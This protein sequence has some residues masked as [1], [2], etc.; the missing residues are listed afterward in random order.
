MF[1]YVFYLVVSCQWAVRRIKNQRTIASKKKKKSHHRRFSVMLAVLCSRSTKPR[2]L[3][4][5][6]SSFAHGSAVHHHHNHYYTDPH[7]RFVPGPGSGGPVQFADLAVGYTLH[8]QRRRHHSSSCQLGPSCV[9]GAASIWHAILPSAGGGRRFDRRRPAIHFD[10]KGEG[11][12]NA[13]VDARPARWLHRADPAWLLFGV[14]ACLAPVVD[15]C[16]DTKAEPPVSEQKLV[17]SASQGS[18]SDNNIDRSADYR[19]KGYLKLKFLY[20]CLYYM[21]YN[22]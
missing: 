3:S 16:A 9:G 20:K 21:M 5:F 8:D 17:I 6:L 15:W 7:P 1:V 19:V 4:A 18:F 12:W 11:S 2:F 10:L 22:I 13:A 14:C